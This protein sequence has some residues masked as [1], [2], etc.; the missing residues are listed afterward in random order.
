MSE[1]A[2][3][4]ALIFVVIATLSWWLVARLIKILIVRDIVDR[5]NHRTLHQGAV[6][7]GGGLVIV[8]ALVLALM[9]VA[10]TSLRPVFF[11]SLTFLVLA[12][13]AL[14]W[15][16]DKHDLSPRYRL[17]VQLILCCLTVSGFG[18]VDQ[19]YGFQLGIVGAFISLIGVLWMANLY[20]FMD[21]LDGLAAAQTI[22]ASSTLSFWF[23]ISGD[24]SLAIVCLV[25]AA[26][27]Y[28]FILHNWSPATIFMGDVGSITIGAFFGILIIV[29]SVWHDIS[30]LSFIS[31]F[32]VFIV[33][34]S[35]TIVRRALRREKIWL[36]HRQ[37]FYQRL[38]SAGYSHSYIAL[39]AIILM[40]L[41]SLLATL[42]V[43]YHDTIEFSVLGVLISLIAAIFA[44]IQLE[45]RASINR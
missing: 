20:N 36:P 9:C 10:V 6:P 45:R 24:A 40:I 1:A 26:A 28:G 41:C 16:D 12:W 8:L 27:S 33:D 34:S 43:A 21:G 25:L 5:P 38:A 15:W 44:V 23:Y 29:G 19:I 32:A 11:L 18:W 42:S 31:L 22:I 3:L 37:H 17:A 4:L 39:A 30:V 7:R 2:L 14:S 35:F 13:A